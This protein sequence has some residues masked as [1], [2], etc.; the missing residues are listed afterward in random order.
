LA[1]VES[2]TQV[3]DKQMER[4]R[5]H[6][7]VERQKKI[8]VTSKQLVEYYNGERVF[9]N[10]SSKKFKKHHDEFDAFMN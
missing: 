6:A 2:E 8:L 9:K 1:R 7:E 10:I 3:K 4:K 5:V